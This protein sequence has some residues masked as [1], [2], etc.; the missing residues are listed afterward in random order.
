[1][2]THEIIQIRKSR[3]V[4]SF[5]STLLFDP[6]PSP[7]QRGRT[8][9]FDIEE[10]DILLSTGPLGERISTLMRVRGYPMAG[11]KIAVGIGTNAS[12]VNKGLRLLLAQERIE[13]VEIPG[14]MKEYALR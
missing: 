13:V 14:N 12:Q 4:K 3:F 11:R 7:P 6:I 5:L 2:G 10:P 9:R 8:V 1:M